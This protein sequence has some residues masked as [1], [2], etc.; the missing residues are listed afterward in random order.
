MAYARASFSSQVLMLW[1]FSLFG[2]PPACKNT[3]PARTSPRRK[4]IPRRRVKSSELKPVV[5]GSLAYQ[6]PFR[7]KS[8]VAI[9]Q[10]DRRLGQPFSQTFKIFCAVPPSHTL[11][12]EQFQ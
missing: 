10:G 11:S 12:F 3:P 2:L 9:L 5:K 6:E 8:M 4:N 7:R 1:A